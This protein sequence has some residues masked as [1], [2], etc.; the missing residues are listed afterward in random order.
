MSSRVLSSS[1]VSRQRSRDA[2]LRPAPGAPASRRGSYSHDDNKSMNGAAEGEPS[3]PRRR[4]RNLRGSTDDLLK[5][6]IVV[7]VRG[8]ENAYHTSRLRRIKRTIRA[9]LVQTAPSV[10]FSNAAADAPSINASASREP[11]AIEPRP[12]QPSRRLSLL[13]IL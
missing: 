2:G 1:D 5:P 6:T 13:P 11:A 12:F 3:E 7:K 10:Q 4:Q 9:N 8:T